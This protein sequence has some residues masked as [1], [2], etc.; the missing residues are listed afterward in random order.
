M[1]N[2]IKSGDVVTLKSGGVAMTVD[3]VG[4]L[5]PEGDEDYANLEWMDE[6]GHMQRNRVPVKLLKKV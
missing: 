1:S 5:S 3:W 6:H 4:R 2:Q